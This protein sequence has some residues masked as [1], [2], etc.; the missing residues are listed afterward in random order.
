[1]RAV[2]L[3]ETGLPTR[4]YIPRAD[5]RSEILRPSDRQ[6]CCPYKGI[7]AYHAVTVGNAQYGDLVWYYPDP[8]E[9]CRKITG[10]L[11]F[12][13]EKVDG[14]LVDGEVMP[15]PVTPWSNR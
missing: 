11:A 5:V 7:A 6:T 10:L 12:F 15:R 8:I 13:N 2:F 9:D 4:Y 1:R 3:F 14:I